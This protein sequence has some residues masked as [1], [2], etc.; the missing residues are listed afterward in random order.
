MIL[1]IIS[2][3]STVG[4]NPFIYKSCEL[5][6]LK[7]VTPCTTR[8]NRNEETNGKDYFSYL[9]QNFNPK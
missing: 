3:P 5:Y 4:K 9:F 6:G 8:L 1:I 2:G 7:Y